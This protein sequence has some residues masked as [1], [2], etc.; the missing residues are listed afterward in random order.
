MQHH[1]GFICGFGEQGLQRAVLIRNRVG[2][3]PA[4]VEV[5]KL[6]TG[7]NRRTFGPQL[8]VPAGIVVCAAMQG[9]EPRSGAVE[10]HG[11]ADT[12]G[13]PAA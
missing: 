9:G 6:R 4:Q 7:R 5:E 8:G 11:R 2:K 13:P 3:D 12:A 10:R 1:D